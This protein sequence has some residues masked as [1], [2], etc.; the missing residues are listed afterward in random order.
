M[1]R[2]H[3]LAGAN[4]VVR[5]FVTREFSRFANRERIGN[6]VL[7]EAVRRVERGSID[8]DLGGG[9]IKQ[10]VARR[11]QGKS[12]G[13]RAILLFREGERAFFV[14]GFAKNDR[15][16]IGRSELGSLRRLG[17]E[18]LAYTDGELALKIEGG[19][20]AEVARNDKATVQK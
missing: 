4:P 5:I 13:F 11:G 1:T 14:Y 10:R 9:V 12:R 16:N 18:M 3:G 19:A 15:A 2:S 17:T 8:A 7:V 6:E 20:I